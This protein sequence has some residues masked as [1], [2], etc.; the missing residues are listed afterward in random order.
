MFEQQRLDPRTDTRYTV[1]SDGTLSIK[2]LDFSD[3]GRYYCVA[4]NTMGIRQSGVGYLTVSG[5]QFSTSLFPY[6]I[7]P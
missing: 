5:R 3:E 7:P 6:P 2:N 4:E 1:D